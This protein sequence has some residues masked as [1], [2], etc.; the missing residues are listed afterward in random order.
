MA[1]FGSCLIRSCSAGSGEKKREETSGEF[2]LPPP[3][4]YTAA[5][6][7]ASCL[8]FCRSRPLGFQFDGH[9]LKGFIGSIFRQVCKRCRLTREQICP[10]FESITNLA[11]IAARG[12]EY[13]P[14]LG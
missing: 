3:E 13:S 10:T 8:E 5:H 14:L 7:A 1:S 11:Y 12:F 2:P 9:R 4:R 6:P